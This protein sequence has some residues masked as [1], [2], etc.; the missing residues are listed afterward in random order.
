MFERFTD[1]ARKILVLSQ[2]FARDHNHSFIGTEHL[3]YGLVAE[4]SGTER[5]ISAKVLAEF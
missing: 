3:L 2:E 4:G 1:R 5:G